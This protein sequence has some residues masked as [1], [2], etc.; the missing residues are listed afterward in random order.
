ME[1]KKM[2]RLLLIGLVV[3]LAMLAQGCICIS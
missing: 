1:G 2:K 3:S